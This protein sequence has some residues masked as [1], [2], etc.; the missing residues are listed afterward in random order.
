MLVHPYIIR[1]NVLET[2]TIAVAF[3]VELKFIAD[4][5][6]LTEDLRLSHALGVI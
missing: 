5:T 4:S 6:E 3:L 1:I 2:K